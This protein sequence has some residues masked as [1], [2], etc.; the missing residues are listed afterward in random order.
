APPIVGLFNIDPLAKEKAI[1]IIMFFALTAWLRA[2]NSI[3]VVGI[4]RSGGD[5]LFSLIL[6][7]GT[8][9]GI[10]VPCA[11]LATLVFKWP[12]EYV[13][14]ATTLESLVKVIIGFP[15]MTSKKWINDI[16]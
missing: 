15:R 7:T 16:T 9:W 8:V 6:D 10:G 12:V 3:N 2:F 1:K 4:L 11:A 13:F 5:T 14:L